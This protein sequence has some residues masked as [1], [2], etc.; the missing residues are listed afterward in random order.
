VNKKT[1][2]E[3]DEEGSKKDDEHQGAK[4][5]VFNIKAHDSN[6]ENKEQLCSGY[7]WF[8]ICIKCMYCLPSGILLMLIAF[9]R[10]DFARCGS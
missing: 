2:E 6:G 3:E 7:V 4:E 5:Y 9:Y 10:T 8:P 1:E